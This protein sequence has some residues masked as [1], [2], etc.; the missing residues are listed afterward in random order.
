M[1]MV[2]IDY[3]ECVNE[4]L[5]VLNSVRKPPAENASEGEQRQWKELH[6]FD[7][8]THFFGNSAIVVS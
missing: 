2:N 1:K 7:L 3:R 6:S 8:L 5:S 4:F